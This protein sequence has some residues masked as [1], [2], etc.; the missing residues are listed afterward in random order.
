[1]A[2]S[3]WGLNAHREFRRRLPGVPKVLSPKSERGS[4]H[5]LS[6]KSSRTGIEVP[7]V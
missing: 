7:A 1:M 4:R 3:G 5:P 6:F 2:T